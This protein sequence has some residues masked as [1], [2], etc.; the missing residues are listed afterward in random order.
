MRYFHLPHSTSKLDH[1][2][3]NSFNYANPKADTFDVE[4][5][6]DHRPRRQYQVHFATSCIR[7][8]MYRQQIVDAEIMKINFPCYREFAQV[9]Q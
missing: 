5:V 6:E 2:L 4:Q 7:R 3:T 9:P 8:I 1:R